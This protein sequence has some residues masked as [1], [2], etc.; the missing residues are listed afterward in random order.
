MRKAETTMQQPE[1][2]QPTVIG[3]GIGMEIK[4]HLQVMHAN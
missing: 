4:N 2:S 1:K 3:A